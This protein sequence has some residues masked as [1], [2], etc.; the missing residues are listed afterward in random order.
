MK[1]DRSNSDIN[2]TY[3]ILLALII[4][5]AAFLR[6][7][8]LDTQGFSDSDEF[9][10]YNFL[11]GNLDLGRFYGTEGS[12][13]GRPFSFLISKISLIIFGENPSSLLI[14]S[15]IA[16]ILTVF[17]IIYI[18][19][20]YYSKYVGVFSG[21]VSATA[22]TLVYYSRNMKQMSLSFLFLSIVL[23]CIF[24]L[25]KQPTKFKYFL[26]GFFISAMVG[27]HPN[28]LPL[29]AI[30]LI[31]LGVQCIYNWNK[32]KDYIWLFYVAILGGS[33]FSVLVMYEM[34]FIII[35]YIPALT[36]EN[37][38]YLLNLLFH[39]SIEQQNKPSFSFYLSLF[40]A[41]G[42][43]FLYLLL[44]S[45]IFLLSSTKE[46]KYSYQTIFL[47]FWSV[48]SIYVLAGDIVAV[49]RNIA[50]T[51]VPAS[52]LIGCTLVKINHYVNVCITKFSKKNLHHITPF[53]IVIFIGGYGAKASWHHIKPVSAA[54]QIFDSLKGSQASFPYPT[55]SLYFWEQYYFTPRE[56][57]VNNWEDVLNNYI[58]GN[59]ESLVKRAPS[60][61]KFEPK[62]FMVNS[63]TEF[64]TLTSS[65][66]Y[67]LNGVYDLT[68]DNGPLEQLFGLNKIISF[69]D[70]NMA[71]VKMARKNMENISNKGNSIQYLV[72]RKASLMTLHGHAKINSSNGEFV[73]I[74]LGTSE[75]PFKYSI[76]VKNKQN[77]TDRLPVHEY[78]SLFNTWVFPENLEDI[79]VSIAIITDNGK[80]VG[81]YVKL[82]DFSVSFY[83]IDDDRINTKIESV[84]IDDRSHESNRQYLRRLSSNSE[85]GQNN[86]NIKDSW[87]TNSYITIPA[88]TITLG[89]CYKVLFRTKGDI[90][91]VSRVT[92]I[93]DLSAIGERVLTT[94]EYS[95]L[96]GEKQ[97]IFEFN[98]PMVSKDIV[99]AYE[100][101][102]GQIK[103]DK[104]N[105]KSM[106]CAREK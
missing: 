25:K 50:I 18:G 106:A 88:E 69:Q 36:V 17:I 62:R 85:S 11:V 104:L 95:T 84:R 12:M 41:N 32:E 60:A 16:G 42:R 40:D 22:F 14:K 29:A 39:A 63:Y 34:F 13:W 73:V 68:T 6:F 4:F 96:F 77:T 28:T 79:N 5:F 87:T 80:S 97:I 8:A 23:W 38:G 58:L 37:V 66:N 56:L 65:G 74:G 98:A 94:K 1:N 86:I 59:A 78:I 26:T 64:K 70:D 45:P 51:L 52:L 71:I 2:I 7:Y 24:S 91:G 53:V 89:G 3:F 30:I 100:S 43:F 82:K 61:S 47:L 103:P 102:I 76:R 101:V 15:G 33:F 44:I 27:S 75:L 55:N 31:Y 93:T 21:A 10:S 83:N 46:Q 54:V 72:P 20:R 67:S 90:I 48:I 81:D 99:I 105:I 57:F 9:A 49:K 35:K 19:E 92:A